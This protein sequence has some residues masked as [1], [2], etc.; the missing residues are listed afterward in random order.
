MWAESVTI[1]PAVAADPDERSGVMLNLS[2]CPQDTL[3]VVDPLPWC[4]HLDAVKPLPLSGIDVFQPCGDCGSDAENWI[5]LTC[6]QVSRLTCP[7]QA[8]ARRRA[9][10]VA[11]HLPRCAAVATSTSTWWRTAPRWNTPWSSASPTC[12]PGATC[13]SPT[14][15]TR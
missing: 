10:P 2:V 13:V 6:Y 4:P 9:S 3:Y 7:R 11:L 1:N 12:L 15:T 14:S 8:G 5:C